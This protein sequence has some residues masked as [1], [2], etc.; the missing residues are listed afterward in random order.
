[1]P[2]RPEESLCALNVPPNLLLLYVRK[3]NIEDFGKR[4]AR[5]LIKR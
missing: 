3:E 5:W 4:Y 2:L 1:M